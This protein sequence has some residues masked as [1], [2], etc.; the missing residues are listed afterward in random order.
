MIEDFLLQRFCPG[1]APRET[2]RAELIRLCN[3]FI[4]SGLADSSFETELTNGE[5]GALWSRMSEALT[6]DLLRHSHELVDPDMA[7]GPDFLVTNGDQ[8]VW[9]EVICPSPNDIPHEWL[10][11]Q[12]GATNFPHEA[13]LLRWTAAIK[14]KAEKCIGSACGKKKGYIEKGIVNTDDAYVIAV[15]GCQLRNGPFSALYGI[16][17]F[18]F[19]VEALF[20]VGPI[21][22]TMC[23]ETLEVVDEGHQFRPFILNKNKAEVPADTFLDP[24]YNAISAVWA[25]DLN[26]AAVLDSEQPKVVVHNPN[27]NNPL[28]QGF[29]PADSDFVTMPVGEDG[30]VLNRVVVN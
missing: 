11:F 13:I 30:Y 1:K 22:V 23:K 9:I 6:Y 29:L 18:P 2:F 3:E 12:E 16:S 21:Q 14:E 7:A 8:R 15:N 28:P 19:A 10:V 5:D 4:A 24:R 20:P 27:A 25:I 26:G 17:Q